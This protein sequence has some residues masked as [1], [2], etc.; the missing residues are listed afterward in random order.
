MGGELL[1]SLKLRVGC[2]NLVVT[3]NV[4]GW[5][6]TF[7]RIGK[8]ARAV[9]QAPSGDRTRLIGQPT[10]VAQDEFILGH[11]FVI[12]QSQNRAW[13]ELVTGHLRL[14]RVRKFSDVKLQNSLLR[15]SPL[16]A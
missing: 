16:W 8:K 14:R 10:H 3:L 2:K 9:N 7:R 1:A 4:D 15:F 13:I 12:G 5:S 6:H 11:I